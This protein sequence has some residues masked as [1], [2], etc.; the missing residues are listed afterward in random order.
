MFIAVPTPT[1]LSP[2]GATCIILRLPRPNQKHI[3]DYT[4]H[5]VLFWD[6]G[7]SCF[8]SEND[9]NVELGIGINHDVC[10]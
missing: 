8:D 10:R 7:L 3:S 6:K 1:R 9:M 2:R 4:E 5:F